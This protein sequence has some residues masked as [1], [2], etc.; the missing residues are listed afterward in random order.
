MSG[1]LW[2]SLLV[3]T[4]VAITA[5]APS[6]PRTSGAGA[7]HSDPAAPTTPA[8]RTLVVG[9]HVE[10]T[11]LA[12]RPPVISGIT[13]GAPTHIFSDWLVVSDG[14]NFPRPRLAGRLPQLNS[15]DWQVFPDGTME[16]R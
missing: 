7:P 9:M 2:R 6:A 4:A 11:T 16:T 14:R 8:S 5:C 12:P 15:S 13:L 1:K 3:I 10:P